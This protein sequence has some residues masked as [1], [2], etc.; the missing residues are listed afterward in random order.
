[1]STTEV[2]ATATK[3]DDPTRWVR[4]TLALRDA[5]E[6]EGCLA[7]AAVMTCAVRPR[8]ELSATY[9]LENW[10]S[11][12]LSGYFFVCRRARRMPPPPLLLSELTGAL[13]SEDM[14][15]V[16]RAAEAAAARLFG[17]QLPSAD[18]SEWVVTVAPLIP[19]GA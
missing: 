9:L 17:I 4:L 11:G 6:G 10:E 12:L 14:S 3:A 19:V 7:H 18:S 13:G 16:V 15:G 1:M 2:T 5:D 8:D